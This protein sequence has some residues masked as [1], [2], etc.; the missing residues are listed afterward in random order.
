MLLLMVIL[1]W[2][3]YPLSFQKGGISFHFSFMELN[4][5]LK[6]GGEDMGEDRGQEVVHKENQMEIQ[7]PCKCWR[8]RRRRR[9][10]R[11]ARK[12][13]KRRT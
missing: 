7:H 10:R 4:F 12:D 11:R 1:L 8:S 3:Q 13:R 9:R 2:H 6:D 5:T